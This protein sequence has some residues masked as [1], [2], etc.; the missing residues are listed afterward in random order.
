MAQKIS[1]VIPNFNGKNLLKKN[2]PIVIK[3]CPSAEII[4][5][6][7]KSTDDSVFMI[8]KEFKKVKLI[9]HNKNYGFAKA[10][11]TGV[12]SAK[13]HLVLLLNS[14]VA[15]KDNFIRPAVNHFKNKSN[16]FAVGLLD[17]SHEGS[18]IRVKG[19]GG[20]IFKRGLVLHFPLPPERAET[21]WVSGGSG[22]FDRKKFLELGG[23]DQIYKPFYW[24][25]IDLSFRAQKSGYK[26]IFE[27]L[28]K[29]DHFHEEGAISTQK[30]ELSINITSYKNQFIFTWK[31]ITS[32][33]LVLLHIFWLPFHMLKA[34]LSLNISFFI[35][36]IWA[37]EKLPELIYNETMFKNHFIIPEKDIF[38]KYAKQ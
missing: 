5:V 23:F 15:P 22:L 11:N 38:K 19:R 30:T 2:L 31:N 9:K 7:D 1:V 33:D 36:F 37:L 18:K 13:N 20:A 8:R 17:Y 6:D 10:A 3:N 16:L 34:S 21:F 14:D 24:E 26:C 32:Y 28:S 35:G 25:D 12:T 4:V 27:P 29:V